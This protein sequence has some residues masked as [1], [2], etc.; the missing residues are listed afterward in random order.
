MSCAIIGRECQGGMYRLPPNGLDLLKQRPTLA[1][2]HSCHPLSR[3]VEPPPF[4]LHA[5]Y[6]D[7]SPTTPLIFVLSAGSDPTA[8][9]LQFAGK[10]GMFQEGE[11]KA[12]T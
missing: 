5:C 8:A 1:P 9:L 7:S 2:A 10:A 6:A 4:N 11:C 3:Y 12:A